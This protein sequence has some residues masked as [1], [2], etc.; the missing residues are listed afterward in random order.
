MT[1]DVETEEPGGEQPVASGGRKK[2]F[3]IVGAALA[4]LLIGGGAGFYFLVMAPG[5]KETALVADVKSSYYY[6]LPTM[7]VN[8]NSDKSEFL[9]LSVSLAARRRS[10]GA[11]DRAEH[12]AR[13]R[14]L[15]GL[16][17]GIAPVR[18]RRFRRHLPAQGRA[19]APGQSGN[20]SR[21][22]RRASCSRKSWCSRSA[23]W[24]SR[25]TRTTTSSPKTGGWTRRL[26]APPA[27]DP[28]RAKRKATETPTPWRPNG[29]P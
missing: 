25:A 10:Y 28:A 2:L 14:R 24:P 6:E 5:Q 17:A 3:M 15:S 20:L 16:S 19:A 13:G 11:G 26:E 27:K 22:D 9:K 23:Q 29:P 12:C 7:T 18:P 1:D 8:L 4:L 21:Q